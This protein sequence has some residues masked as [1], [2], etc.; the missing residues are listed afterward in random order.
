[1]PVFVEPNVN[2]LVWLHWPNLCILH[3]VVL[4]ITT[5]QD[6]PILSVQLAYKKCQLFIKEL[7]TKGPQ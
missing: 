3:N 5:V 7:F 2:A 4:I 6:T 1:M